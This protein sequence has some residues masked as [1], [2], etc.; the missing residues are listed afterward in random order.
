MSVRILK[1]KKYLKHNH[2]ILVKV[3]GIY[4]SLCMSSNGVVHIVKSIPLSFL[5]IVPSKKYLML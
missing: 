1:K 4:I 5:V 2:S 3:L